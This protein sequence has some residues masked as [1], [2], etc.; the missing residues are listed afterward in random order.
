MFLPVIFYF[1][2]NWL[3][4]NSSKH[5]NSNSNYEGNK[6]ISLEENN[7]MGCVCVYAL[8]HMCICAP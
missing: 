6:V 4:N 1:D 2:V 8:R 5:Y 7:L 3:Y